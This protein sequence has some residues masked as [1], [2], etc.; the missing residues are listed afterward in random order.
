MDAVEKDQ[1]MYSTMNEDEEPHLWE[2]MD[3]MRRMMEDV[4]L[5][6]YR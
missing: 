3:V 6:V 5:R 1:P 2:E 4:G